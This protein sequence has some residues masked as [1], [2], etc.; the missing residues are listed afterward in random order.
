MG[1][2]GGGSGWWFAS[3]S[4]AETVGT[5]R[6]FGKSWGAD[7]CEPGAWIP[8]PEDECCM[9]CD[10]PIRPS[11][12]GIRIPGVSTLYALA[13]YHIGCWLDLLKSSAE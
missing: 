5:V 11:D 4:N 10:L 2:D 3:P 9:S 12:Q 8:T 6:W 13:Y 7:A 1:D